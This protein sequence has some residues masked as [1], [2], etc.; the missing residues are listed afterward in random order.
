MGISLTGLGQFT[1][2]HINW[3]VLAD[4]RIKFASGGPRCVVWNPFRVQMHSSLTSTTFSYH[5]QIVSYEIFIQIPEQFFF[6][7]LILTS[8][9]SMEVRL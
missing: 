5:C 4:L 8:Q 9:G 6:M 7:P 2:F 3:E 1:I